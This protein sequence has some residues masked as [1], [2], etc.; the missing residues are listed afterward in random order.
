MTNKLTAKG[1]FVGKVAVWLLLTLGAVLLAL[2]VMGHKPQPAEAASGCGQWEEGSWVNKGTVDF[3]KGIDLTCFTTSQN[4]KPAHTWWVEVWV[5]ETW[6]YGYPCPS[7]SFSC[8]VHWPAK[9]A[10]GYANTGEIYVIYNHQ[11]WTDTLFATQWDKAIHNKN[12][13]S[14]TDK[15]WVQVKRVG[16]GNQQGGKD[17]TDDLLTC[18][19]GPCTSH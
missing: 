8:T 13:S 9:Q 7:S 3:V 4:G 14:N 12:P 19:S 1:G 10:T 11:Y 5:R 6:A 17:Q 18:S 2:V 15:L 16:K